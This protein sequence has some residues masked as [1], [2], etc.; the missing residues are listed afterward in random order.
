MRPPGKAARCQAV[1]VDIDL[2]WLVL[3]V[4]P[5]V[6]AVIILVIGLIFF[7]VLLPPTKRA[8]AERRE[9]PAEDPSR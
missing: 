4:T 7:R 3:I 5:I 6:L 8:L 9:P 1:G 2:L